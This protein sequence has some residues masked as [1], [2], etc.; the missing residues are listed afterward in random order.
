MSAQ[1]GNPLDHLIHR[2][3]A[4]AGHAPGW[5]RA[6][7]SVRHVLG[8]RAAVLARHDFASGRGEWL[9]ESPANSVGRQ[10][11]A[12]EHSTRNP[13]FISSLEYRP[14][15][16]MT[17]DEL[18]HPEELVRT[19]FYRRQLQQLGLLHRLCGV[20]HRHGEVVWYLDVLRGRDDRAFDAGDRSTFQSILGHV[21]LSLEHH[22]DLL[23]TRELNLALRSIMDGLAA[24]VFVLDR[25]RRVLLRNARATEFLD[26]CT[27]LAL[28]GGRLVAVNRTE[29]RALA[30]AIAECTGPDAAAAG[31]GDHVVTISSPQDLHPT[32]LIVRRAGR[33]MANETGAW[34]NAALLVGKN[35]RQPA[36]DMRLCAFSRIYALTP[37]Q[38]RLAGL[39][40]AGQSLGAC[41][42]ALQVSENTVRSHLK[43]IYQKTDT[44]GRIDLVRLHAQVCTEYL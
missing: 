28:G 14:G 15:R 6:M 7:A 31:T 9:F 13:W 3:H 20:L 16:V 30:E 40:L 12:A 38:A 42:R 8:G 17:G 41:A 11:Y 18:L 5:S 23:G 21:S 1:Q 37:A 24:A 43:Q 35:P 2:I 22:W 27:G 29:D 4:A 39:I 34:D 33:I 26:Q 36:H 19:D 32:V 44:H 10:V 25:R